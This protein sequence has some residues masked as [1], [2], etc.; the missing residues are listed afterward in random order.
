MGFFC[1]K[2][3]PYRN[4]WW[5]CGIC[6]AVGSVYIFKKYACDK[7][8]ERPGVERRRLDDVYEGTLFLILSAETGLSSSSLA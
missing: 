8:N 5:L 3:V 2:Y 6:G 7:K 1:F 4:G